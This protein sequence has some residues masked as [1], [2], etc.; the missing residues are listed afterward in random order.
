[1]NAKNFLIGGIIGGITD[2]LLGWVIHGI[3]LHDAAGPNAGKENLAIIALG[4]LAFG[5][6][7]SYVFN[8]GEGISNWAS[9]MK[10]GAVIGLLMCLW[11]DFF[12]NMY[13]QTLDYKM[14]A[15]HALISIVT[16][17]IVGGVIATVNGKMK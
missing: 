7:L 2:F 8:L 9:G 16:A 5:L 17:G 11:Y 4:C 6:L 10:A 12:N 14:L 1:M 13:S 15:M 3:I